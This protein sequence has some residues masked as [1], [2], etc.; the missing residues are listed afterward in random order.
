MTAPYTES[1]IDLEA[2]GKRGKKPGT[3]AEDLRNA[4]RMHYGF[5]FS[6]RD[7]LLDDGSDN[8]RRLRTWCLARRDPLAAARVVNTWHGADLTAGQVRG[9]QR[10]FGGVEFLSNR[11]ESWS[12]SGDLGT[13]NE[14][15]LSRP[16]PSE[17]AEINL[18]TGLLRQ[19]LL[20]TQVLYALLAVPGVTRGPQGAVTYRGPVVRC[21]GLRSLPRG[22]GNPSTTP[23]AAALLGGGQWER[24]PG[25]LATA[26]A[27]LAGELIDGHQA[28][29]L[30]GLW[31][32]NRGRGL[33]PLAVEAAEKWLAG[34]RTAM[35]FRACVYEDGTKESMLLGPKG[36]SSTAEVRYVCVR[37]PELSDCTIVTPHGD[38]ERTVRPSDARIEGGWIKVDGPEPSDTKR[39]AGKIALQLD[40]YP[41]KAAEWQVTA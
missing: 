31:D 41:D 28:A 3:H 27:S 37:G 9:K 17:S 7:K 36:P 10:Y 2:G 23:V 19:S 21:A 39:P 20:R 33:D 14:L 6:V 26:I 13:L 11:Y 1:D 32:G 38:D 4:L 24:D 18:A 25:P 30:S 29:V 22:V 8:M 12:G 16:V 40:T 35:H 34:T 5:S 15:E